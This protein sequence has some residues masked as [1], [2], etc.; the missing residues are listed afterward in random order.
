METKTSAK[1]LLFSFLSA[2]LFLSSCAHREAAVNKE[3]TLKNLQTAYN[4][5]RNA[6]VRYTAIPQK[7]DEEGY[8]QVASLF[9]AVARAEQAHYEHEAAAIKELGGIPD[10]N[11]ETSVVNTTKENLEASLQGEIYETTKM[12]PEFLAE[13]EKAQIKSAIYAFKNAKAAEAVHAEWYK[14][15][16]ADLNGWKGQKKEFYVCPL[17]GNVVDV[18]VGARCP[19][20]MEDTKK[21]I[22]IN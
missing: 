16:L 2:I 20:C 22:A 10:A 13:A 12:Y 15:A 4:G 3:T 6:N 14:K 18:I 5:E 17:C 8:G 19:I 21:F 1:V 9:R 7:A 11:I